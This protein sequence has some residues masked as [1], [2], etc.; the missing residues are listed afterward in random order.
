MPTTSYHGKHFWIDLARHWKLLS[1]P[2]RPSPQ[3]LA[4]YRR[5]LVSS[6]PKRKQPNILVLGS[7]PEIRDLAHAVHANVTIVDIN[8]EMMRAMTTLMKYRNKVDREVWIR[9]SWVTAP[10]R[11]H[12]FDAILGDGVM[13]NTPW[14]QANQ[15][16]KHLH[17]LLKPRGVFISRTFNA[18]PIPDVHENI[19]RLMKKLVR[20]TTFRSEDIGMLFILLDFLDHN[21]KAKTASDA[22]NKKYFLHACRRLGIP[23]RARDRIRR[24]LLRIYPIGK[25]VW[26][27]PTNEQMDA[28]IQRT[29]KILHRVPS[30]DPMLAPCVFIYVL[31]PRVFL[32]S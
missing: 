12:S 16:W 30:P 28:E 20:S 22:D 2:M 32:P 17:D 14:N 18:M 7:T 1:T 23:P 13:A 15:W 10:L 9:T 5:Y 4:I 26:R 3:D 19:Q 27:L 8:A 24:E 31:R 29:F 21:P 6:L 11:E 25:K